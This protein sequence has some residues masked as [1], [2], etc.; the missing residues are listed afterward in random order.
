MKKFASIS[1][2]TFISVFLH[3]LYGQGNTTP[4][5]PDILRSQGCPQWSSFG[6]TS[7]QSIDNFIIQ[8]PNCSELPGGLGIGIPFGASDITNLAGLQNIRSVDGPLIIFYNPSLVEL[9]GLHNLREVSRWINIRNNEALQSTMAL[10]IMN[11]SIEYLWIENN[12]ALMDIEG[13]KNL[14]YVEKEVLID[15]NSSLENLHGLRN[16]NTVGEGLFVSNN[17]N[18]NSV[19]GLGALISAGA[20]R[21]TNNPLLKDFSG[22]DGL[23]IINQYL[24]VQGNDGLV[25]LHGLDSLQVI[26][27]SIMP[28]AYVGALKIS[29]NTHLKDISALSKLTHLN[30]GLEI[31]NN[32]S[33]KSL[34]G[35]E[36]IQYIGTDLTISNNDSLLNL[37][38]LN[39][40]QK[41]GGLSIYNPWFVINGNQMLEDI[42]GLSSL[43]SIFGSF[44][45]S[46]NPKLKQLIG[47]EKLSYIKENLGV[48]SMSSIKNLKGI[49]LVKLEILEDLLIANNDSLSTLEGIEA[50]VSL[51]GGISIKDN[52]SLEN[53]N[54]L[55]NIETLNGNLAISRNTSLN[56]IAAL[57][58]LQNMNGGNI[59]IFDNDFLPSLS[60]LDNLDPESVTQ[61]LISRN[62]NLSICAVQGICDFLKLPRLAQ[63][64]DNASGCNSRPEVNAICNKVCEI[65]I[66][67]QAEKDT[68]CINDSID[69]SSEIFEGVEPYRYL[70]STGDTTSNIILL[71]I[72][73]NTY[74]L[75]VVDSEDCSATA[76]ISITVISQ[77]D[78]QI[79]T[80]ATV[81]G[82][83]NGSAEI[84]HDMNTYQY[85]WN[86]GSIERSLSNLPAGE[87]SVIV[88][89]QFGCSYEL[90]AF[91]EDSEAIL[92][93][94]LGDLSICEDDI[95]LLY[96]ENAYDSFLW[97]D[98]SQESTLDYTESGTYS[99]TVTEG[100]CEAEDSV[101]VEVNNIP[102]IDFTVDNLS[103]IININM[104]LYPFEVLWSTG[105]STLSIEPKE[106]GLYSVTVTDSNGCSAAAETHFIL[107]NAV[108]F[109][110]NQISVFPNPIRDWLYVDMLQN[111][112][113][114][115]IKIFDAYGK[116]IIQKNQLDNEIKICLEYLPAGPYFMQITSHSASR[117]WTILKE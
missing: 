4:K 27:T 114:L 53:L 59:G 66:I 13:F 104:G 37:D 88:T 26:G 100:L 45:I 10:N 94:I 77:P 18:L 24:F 83:I 29:N 32:M 58:S 108:D 46:N 34:K 33:L 97:S 79:S 102:L 74:R 99:I 61:I 87:V 103:I 115:K 109:D 60:G 28:D 25:S 50:L 54:G 117:V 78:L 105:E 56:S 42:S 72:A 81:C 7:Q 107:T 43:D 14:N 36:N 22:L 30:D 11:T 73:S 89:D 44:G 3:Y 76:E 41:I 49:N 1:I 5:Y 68:I 47:L 17:E 16:I 95:G 71:P 98:G 31:S 65:E 111:Y 113:P 62:S 57:M 93:E 91:I 2:I 92:V 112:G 51:G 6:F 70:W 52:P 15:N 21:I 85:L 23:R 110:L 67:L 38:A 116:L 39:K 69:I 90:S 20:I 101:M 86:N 40:L 48:S 12:P 80:S 63:F 9:D 19:Q 75:T 64:N 82:E 84:L 96:V 35:L 106:S 8:W 55:N